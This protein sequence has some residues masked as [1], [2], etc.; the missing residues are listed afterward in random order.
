MPWQPLIVSVAPTGAFKT[1]KHHPQLPLSPDEV[2]LVAKQS[3]EIGAAMIHLHIRD[4]HSKHSIDPDIYRRATK[5]VRNAV[6]NNMIIQATSESV[7]V[8]SPPQQIAA[9]RELKP[10]A[11]SVALREI[12]PDVSFETEAG[13]FL[14]WLADEHIQTQYVLYSD[15][16]VRKYQDLLQRGVI[17]DAKHWLLFVLGRYTKGQVSTPQ[18]LIPFVST[19]SSD[20]RW[21]MCAF[22]QREHDCAVC[23]ATLGGHMRIGF[24]NNLLLKDGSTAPNN[25]ESIKQVVATINALGRP[26]ATADQLRDYFE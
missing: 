22:G 6:G 19:H 18:D 13:K 7:G 12:V 26:L 2:A 14:K 17:P 23:A 24:E 11:V 21:A 20:V 4:E 5:V 8:Y 25:I 10:E 16:D 9:I 1:K 15:E 3:M